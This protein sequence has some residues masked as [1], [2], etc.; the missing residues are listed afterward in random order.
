MKE[1]STTRGFAVLSAAGFLVKILSVLYIPI[2]TRILGDQGYG[3]YSKIYEVFIFIYAVSNAG[4]QPAICKVI[5]EFS[6]LGRERDALRAFR[7]ARKLLLAVGALFTILLIAAAKPLAYMVGSDIS[8]GLIAVAPT[9]LISSVLVSYRGYLNGKNQM[10]SLALSQVIEQ[11]TNV[12]ISLLFAYLLV[13]DSLAL[14]SAGGASGTSVGALIGCIYLIV[15]FER[16]NFKGEIKKQPII[17]NRISNKTIVKKIIQYGLPITLSAGLSNFGALV[18][19]FN[20]SSRLMYIGYN[21]IDADILYGILSKY[22]NLMYVPL[23][24]ITALG[25]A[26]LP[27]ISKAVVLK[28]RKNVRGKINFALRLTYGITIPAAF[29]LSLL[30]KYIYLGF[31]GNTNGS[32]LMIFGAFVVILMGLSQIET[33]ILQGLGKFRFVLFSLFLGIVGKISTNYILIGIKS[34]NI[35]GAVAGGFVCFMIPVIMNH[36]KLE[37]TIR[38]R[39]HIVR[40]ALK[41]L[42]ASVIMTLC[43]YGTDK[44]ILNILPSNL[45]S[46]RIIITLMTVIYVLLGGFVYLYMMILI[47][48]I[49][50][51]DIE[52]LSPK[53]LKILPGFMKRKLR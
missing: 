29:G 18:D 8:Y 34:I 5:S 38:M 11:L 3:I 46:D 24:F 25:A 32:S 52:G 50:R 48:G 45:A 42:L 22:K 4:M 35:Y 47:K 49:R 15:V 41:P 10:N 12:F 31:Y 2:L 6:A 43:L 44:L 1:Q 14:G 39:I 23:I 16:R 30:N 26:V 20:V 7:L 36:R 9:I 17:E 40:L 28:D 53:I 19:M 27:A 13:K 33:T 51:R 37:K 21:Q